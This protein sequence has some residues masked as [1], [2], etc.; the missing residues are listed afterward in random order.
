[1]TLDEIMAAFG[2]NGI[3]PIAEIAVLSDQAGCAAFT[4]MNYK[5]MDS[6]TSW[7]D[8]SMGVPTRWANPESSA[9]REYFSKITA[10][11]TAANLLRP[12]R[13]KKFPKLKNLTQVR[14]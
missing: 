6:D 4:D 10:E 2:E 8:Y 5:I 1:M 12:E 9:V 11:I 13:L 14:F 3:V 7:L